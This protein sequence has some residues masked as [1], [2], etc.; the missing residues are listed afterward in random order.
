MNCNTPVFA[1]GRNPAFV[2]AVIVAENA[3]F[4]LAR[5]EMM[6][7][8]PANSN[9]NAHQHRVCWMKHA[10]AEARAKFAAQFAEFGLTV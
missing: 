6:A 5:A 4:A 7:L 2:S 8:P 1:V 10:S 9:E 3:A